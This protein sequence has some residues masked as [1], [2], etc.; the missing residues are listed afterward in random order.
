MGKA[1][2]NTSGASSRCLGSSV[3]CDLVFFVA[4]GRFAFGVSPLRLTLVAC[5]GFALF[6]HLFGASRWSWSFAFY[7][8]VVSFVLNF[9]P[10]FY[11]FRFLASSV[12]EF[13]LSFFWTAFGVG[14]VFPRG[15]GFSL[16]H[17]LGFGSVRMFRFMFLFSAP[18][19]GRPGRKVILDVY[20]S[21]L[22]SVPSIPPEENLWKSKK[23]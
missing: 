19:V 18:G 22:N 15:V 11:W 14:F 9:G 8:A 6:F 3:G 20:Y 2:V 13:R 5:G 16:S 10:H 12:A 1:P 23:T 7:V 17:P 4:F 21:L